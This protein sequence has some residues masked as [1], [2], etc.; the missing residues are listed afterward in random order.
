MWSIS[1]VLHFENFVFISS[2]H[3]KSNIAFVSL[4]FILSYLRVQRYV[5]HVLNIDV[6]QV[7][8]EDETLVGPKKKVHLQTG[9]LYVHNIKVRIAHDYIQVPQAG[10]MRELHR[11]RWYWSVGFLVQ[12]AQDEFD[13]VAN[14]A[15]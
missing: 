3:L 8:P 13:T 12:D 7:R 10:R 2:Q 9:H 6:A 4:S 15:L 14:C 1:D 5:T 11:T